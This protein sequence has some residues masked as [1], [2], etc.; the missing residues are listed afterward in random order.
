M[1]EDAAR[2]DR[3]L[4]MV[5]T[6]VDCA[7]ELAVAFG[8][9][10]KAEAAHRPKIELVDAFNRCFQ[11]VRLG[12]RLSLTLRAPPKPAAAQEAAG[13]DRTEALELPEAADRPDHAEPRERIEAERDRD[14]EPVSLPKFLSTLGVAAAAAGRLEA[15]LPPHVA[16]RT[17][18]TLDVLLAEAR[19]E[20]PEPTPPGDLL[21][22]PKPVHGEAAPRARLLGSA[23]APLAPYPRP[24]PS[25]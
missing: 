21:V 3:E 6:L 8:A 11:A 19:T 25:G 22:R 5:E 7:H 14:Y 12:I 1:T 16:E 15:H 13:T 4:Q 20:P 9:A 18:P 24:P 10:A 17:L 2:S 23:A